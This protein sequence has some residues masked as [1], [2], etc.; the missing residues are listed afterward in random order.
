MIALQLVQGPIGEAEL[1]AI[2]RTYGKVD[3]RYQ[4]AGFCRTLFNENPFGYSWHA[5]VLDAGVPVGHYAVIPIRVTDR[6]RRIVSG[7]GEALYLAE[8]HR[9]TL[10][11]G[12]HGPMPA[13]VALMQS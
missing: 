6:G 13:G 11:E 5:F 2:G 12:D 7:K 10:V 1:A 4:S 8:T 3:A 9:A